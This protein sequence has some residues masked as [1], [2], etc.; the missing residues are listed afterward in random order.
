[1]RHDKNGA[2]IFR[3]SRKCKDGRIIYARDY[4]KKAF[5]IYVNGPLKGQAFYFKNNTIKNSFTFVKLF[6]IVLTRS[7]FK[8]MIDLW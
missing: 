4:G 1:M 6:F 2:F 3:A 7:V 5:K 8:S